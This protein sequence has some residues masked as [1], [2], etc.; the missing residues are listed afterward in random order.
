MEVASIHAGGVREDTTK[1]RQGNPH[2]QL[3]HQGSIKTAKELARVNHVLRGYIIGGR[4]GTIAITVR[5][6]ARLESNRQVA[7]SAPRESIMIEQD[8]LVGAAKLIRSLYRG[9]LN[10]KS[11]RGNRLFV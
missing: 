1:L 9:T 2:A 5:L 11:A 3:V 4:I 7:T 6:G 10:A 8:R